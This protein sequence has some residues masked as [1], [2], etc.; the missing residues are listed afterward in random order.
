MLAGN[1]AVEARADIRRTREAMRDGP[2][3]AVVPEIAARLRRLTPTLPSGKALRH[4][5][6]PASVG[7]PCGQMQH[8]ATAPWI[9]HVRLK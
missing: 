7:P 5:S 1:D 3:G 4:A 2:T 6:W 9:V 8:R